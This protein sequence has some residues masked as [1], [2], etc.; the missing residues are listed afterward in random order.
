MPVTIRYSTFMA[1]K[2]KAEDQ[3]AEVEQVIA[4]HLNPS[5]HKAKSLR[6]TSLHCELHR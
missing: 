4:H 2:I 3:S 6:L 5:K 1:I